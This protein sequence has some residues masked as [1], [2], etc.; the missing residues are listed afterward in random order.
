MEEPFKT[1]GKVMVQPGWMAVYGREQLGE[2]LTAVAVGEQ[3]QTTAIE[4]E[5]K[6]TKPPARYNEATL[7]SAMEHAGKL[8]DD[9][10]LAEAMREKG[11]GTPATRA[12][13][14]EA[15]IRH[16]YLIRENRELIPTAQAF[17]LITLL[18]GLQVEALSKPEL[19]GDWEHKLHEIER[20]RLD[21]ESFMDEIR[22][23]TEEIVNRAKA[24]ESDTIPG[25]YATL[26]T[27][28]PKCGSVIKENYRRFACSS[29]DCDFDFGKVMGGRFFELA[30]AE[31]LLTNRTIGP[32]QGFRSKMGRPFAAIIKVS[33][34]NKVEFD[35]GNDAEEDEAPPDFSGQEPIGKCLACGA[36]VYEH[37]MQYVCEKTPEKNCTFRSGKVILQRE[38]KRE[39]LAKLLET[40]RTD[41]LEKFIS[42][43]GRPFNAFLVWDEKKK[44]TR[45]EFEPRKAKKGAKAQRDK[46]TKKTAD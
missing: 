44:Q 9:E 3:V 5:G 30:E 17:Q 24:Y 36:G 23:M 15:L 18:H 14:I 28:C 16:R 20:G 10:E 39:E 38:M 37:S 11:L 29:A 45:F 41:L 2:T 33:D 32:L 31:E 12:E 34:E 4:T 46:G 26:K 27:P 43:K 22:G 25:D 40:G 7:L 13:I 6:A 19:T 35:F 42:K 8:V 1:E 21:R